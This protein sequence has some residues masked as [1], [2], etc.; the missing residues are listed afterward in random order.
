MVKSLRQTDLDLQLW[1]NFP[2]LSNEVYYVRYC[3][4]TPGEINTVRHKPQAYGGKVYF[5]CVQLTWGGHLHWDRQTTAHKDSYCSG[6]MQCQ[7][8]SRIMN[9]D[10]NS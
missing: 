9:I 1:Q 10:H 7:G 4:E 6:N 3:Q 2:R 8:L 5:V